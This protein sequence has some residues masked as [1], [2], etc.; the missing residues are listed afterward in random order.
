MKPFFF[1][2]DIGHYR[3]GE[4]IGK[5][6]GVVFAEDAEQAERVAWKKYGGDNCCALSVW[7]IGPDGTNYTVWRGNL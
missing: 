5:C 1:T 7:E 6:T 3:T 4:I 2:L